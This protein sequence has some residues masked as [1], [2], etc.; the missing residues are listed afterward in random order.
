M[1]EHLIACTASAARS[2][3]LV[4]HCDLCGS[5]IERTTLKGLCGRCAKGLESG[6]SSARIM[7]AESKSIAQ[8]GQERRGV[9]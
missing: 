9:R 6:K 8:R 7:V 1:I 5:A 2:L 4:A 3:P